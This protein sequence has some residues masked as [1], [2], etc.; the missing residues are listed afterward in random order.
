MAL[1]NDARVQIVHHVHKQLVGNVGY[2]DD[3]LQRLLEAAAEQR[4][5]VSVVETQ[6]DPVVLVDAATGKLK[7]HV[8]KLLALQKPIQMNERK[9]VELRIDIKGTVSLTALKVVPQWVKVSFVGGT[10]TISPSPS[11]KFTHQGR[12]L[13]VAPLSSLG[14]KCVT[15]MP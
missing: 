6:N 8:A 4:L 2:V 13:G 5:K 15:S 9:H 1:R 10:V 3:T 7:D 11:S 14:A 12:Q